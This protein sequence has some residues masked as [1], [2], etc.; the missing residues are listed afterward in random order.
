MKS[1]GAKLALGAVVC[2]LGV[3]AIVSTIYSI[4][5]YN[6][7]YADAE[8]YI[9]A[10]CREIRNNFND[11][12]GRMEMASDMV[13]YQAKYY[14]LDKR[15]PTDERYE[16]FRTAAV[17]TAQYA[18]NIYSVYYTANRELYDGSRDFFY[19]FDESSGSPREAVPRNPLTFEEETGL[20]AVWYY[21]AAESGKSCWVG[22]YD[23]QSLSEEGEVITYTVPVINSDGDL[24]G[25][26]GME[27]SLRLILEELNR[28][29]LYKNGY[30]FLTDSSGSILYHPTYE[31]GT[32]FDDVQAVQWELTQQLLS[33]ENPEHLIPYTLNGEKR[34][35]AAMR[36]ENDMVMI[37]SV[38]QS[39]INAK[40]YETITEALLVFI[41]I[42]IA[43]NIIGLAFARHFSAPVKK[44][45]EASQ[46]IMEGDMT[47]D[48]DYKGEDEIGILI[49]NFKEMA[50]QLQKRL[51]K[52]STMAYTDVLT[53]VNNQSSFEINAALMDEKIAEN[54]TD[55]GVVMVD[56]NNLKV[57]N[58]RF[59]HTAGDRLIRNSA[60]IISY[61]FTH[62]PVFRVGA[63]EFVILLEKEDF[64]ERDLRIEN[65]KILIDKSNENLPEIKKISLSYGVAVFEPDTDKCFSDVLSRADRL[66]FE[67][68]RLAKKAK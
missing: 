10:Q 56:L 58:E 13:R 16:R 38:P 36:L 64:Y 3:F 8:K 5:L 14:M 65:M 54:Y 33:E 62:S 67:H 49:D 45:S 25:V 30:I 17:E 6:T 57:T 55:F 15:I 31:Y 68:K 32:K 41:I 60:A 9:W 4:S 22:P 11:Q 37:A 44:L 59:G 28:I 27:F 53:G 50:A 35:M 47:V 21:S 63:D 7:N 48:I 34:A 1:I 43:T 12:L 18:H 24:I 20:P 26:I 23:K 2:L 39:D 51:D 66:M 29:S 40:F 52:Y 42:F 61:A 19:I 46:R